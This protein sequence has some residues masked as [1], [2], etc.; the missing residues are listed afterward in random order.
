MNMAACVAAWETQY[1]YLIERR[2]NSVSPEVRCSPCA[3]VTVGSV[4]VSAALDVF[5]CL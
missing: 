3:P 2:L 5:A 1:K 4:V